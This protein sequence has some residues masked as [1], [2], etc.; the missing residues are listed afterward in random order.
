MVWPRMT[1]P[2]KAILAVAAG[3]ALALAGC[4]RHE[5]ADAPGGAGFKVT[6]QLDWV[7][8]PEHG[9]F[10]QALA[11]GYFREAGLDVDEVT[12]GAVAVVRTAPPQPASS[13]AIITVTPSDPANLFG[14]S[15]SSLG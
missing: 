5:P 11:K 12:G 4:T 8:E 13:S 3:L 15:Y 10:Y 14:I 6:V 9:G 7:A 1:T 2:R